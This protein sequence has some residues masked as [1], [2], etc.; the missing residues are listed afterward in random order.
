MR[1]LHLVTKR[2]TVLLYSFLCCGRKKVIKFFLSIFCAARMAELQELLA[3]G[4]SEQKAQET[5]KNRSVTSTILSAI[6][7][8]RAESKLVAPEPFPKLVGNLLYHIGTRAKP[9]IS[10]HIPLLASYV[11][12]GKIDSEAKLNFA[13]AYL[14]DHLSPEIDREKF[15][16]A[17]GVGVQVTSEDVQNTISEVISQHR[18][19]LLQ[20]RY[21]YNVGSLLAAARAKLKF[22][23]GKDIKNELDVQLF[24]LLGPKTALDLAPKPKTKPVGKTTKQGVETKKGAAAAND[25]DGGGGGDQTSQTVSELMKSP[26]MTALHEPGKNH[27]T[28]GYVVTKNTQK[29]LKEHMARTGGR[30]RT[31]FPPEPNGVLHIGHAKAIHVNFGFAKA[32]DGLCFLRYDDTNPEKEEEKFFVAIKEMV[33]WLGYKPYKITHSSDYFHELYEMAEKL[34]KDGLAYVCHQK[35]EEMK[36]FDPPP[37]PWRN[38]PVDENL[39][40]FRAMKDGLFDEGEATLRLKHI[41]EEGKQDPVAYRIKYVP[42]HR[43]GDEWCIYPTY[44]YT[45][46]LCDSLEDITHSLCTKEFQSRRSSYYWLCNALDVYCP[47]QWEYARLNVHR[48][49]V[50][51]RKIASLIKNGIVRDWDD[52]R[53]FTLTAL[54]RRGVPP[55]AIN[56]FVARLGLS[57]AQMAVGPD[58]LDSC[59]RDTLNATAPRTMVVLDPLKVTILNMHSSEKRFEVLDFP[60]HPNSAT[61]MITLLPVIYLERSD[62]RDN[63]AEKDYRRLTCTQSVGLRHAGL[64]ISVKKVLR[65]P[66]GEVQELEVVCCSVEQTRKP[67]AFVH[68]VSDPEKCEVRMY[69][70]LFMHQNPENPDEVPGGFLSDVNPKSLTVVK[71]ALFDEH[72]L[73]DIPTPYKAYQF[74]RQGFFAEKTMLRWSRGCALCGVQ[75]RKVWSRNVTSTSAPLAAAFNSRPMP[76]ISFSFAADEVGLFGKKELRDPTGFY[77][78]KER[79]ISEADELVAEA[80]SQHRTRKLVEIFDDLS[81]SLCRVADLAEFVRIAHPNA[82]FRLAAEDAC[83]AIGGLVEKLN[84]DLKLYESLKDGLESGREKTAFGCDEVDT[85]VAELFKFDFEQC[86]IHLTESKRERVARL[87]EEI[88]Y[89]GQR[90]CSAAN[91]P[92]AVRE[93]DLPAHFAARFRKGGDGTVLISS[94]QADASQETTRELAYKLYLAR[95]HSQ[96]ALLERLLS[97][98]HEMATICGFSTY[99]ERMLSYSL[100][101]NPEFVDE[102]H[103]CLREKL[104]PLAADDFWTMELLKK[105]SSPG[106]GPLA[107]WDPPYYASLTRQKDFGVTSSSVASYFSLG[108]CMEGLD[109]LLQTLYGI[110]LELCEAAPGELWSNDVRKLAVVHEA[111]GLLGYVYCDFFDRHDKPHS[112]CHFTI[113]G[114]R[115]LSDGSYQVPIVVLLLSFPPGGFGT[116]GTFGRTPPCLSP[117]MVDNL[118]HEFGHALHSKGSS[119]GSGPLAPWDP[120]Y[121]AS[122]TRQKDFGVTSSSVASYFSLGSCMEGLDKLLQTLY[123]IRLEL[124]EAAPGE[125]WSNDVRKLAVVHEADGLLGYVYCD[126]F[127]RHDKPHSD[128]H[129]TIQGGRRLSDGSYQVPIV[130]LLLSFPPGGFGTDGT[131]GRTPPCLSPGMVDNLFHEFG[132]ALHSVMGRTRYQH[133]TGT[134]CPTDFAEVPSTMMEFFAGDP[135]VISTFAVH[136]KTGEKMPEELIYRLCGSRHCLFLSEVQNDYYGLPHVPN[137]GWQLRFSHLVG[138]GAKYYSYLMSRAVSAWIWSR[139]FKNDPFDRPGG[140]AV[141]YGLLSH[142][143]AVDPRILVESTVGKKVTPEALSNCLVD[144]LKSKRSEMLHLSVDVLGNMIDRLKLSEVMLRRLGLRKWHTRDKWISG[145]RCYAQAIS[146]VALTETKDSEKIR[147]IGI[148]AHIDSGKTTLTERILYY[149]GRIQEMHEVKGKDNV[150][151]TMDSMELERQRGITIQSAATYTLWKDHN[152]NIIDTPG[153]VDFT[154]EVERALR[155]L[156]GAVLVLCAVGGVQSQTMTVNRQMARYSVPCLAFINKLDRTG[157]NPDRVLAQLRSKLGHN[158]AYMNIPMGKEMNVSGLIDLIEEKAVYFRGSCGEEIAEDSIP[159]EFRALAADRRAELVEHVVNVDELLGEMF[160]EE[161]APTN[162]ELKAAIRRACLKR[163][164]TPVYVG[165]ALKNK[166]VQPLLD[167]ALDFLPNPGEVQNFALLEKEDGGAVEKVPLSANRDNSHPFV[168]LAF[169]LEAGRFGQLTY[170]RVYQGMLKKSDTLF[171]T[172]TRKKVRI[173][174]VVRMHADKLED[175][176]EVYSGD[177]CA[178]FGV[179]CASGDTFVTDPKLRLSME[180]MHVPEPV[181]SMSIAPKDKKTGLENF[182]KA[183]ARFTKEDPTFTV[184]YDDD[185]KELIASGMGELHLEIYGQRMEREFNCPVVMGKPKVAFRESLVSPVEFDYLHKKQSGGAGQYGRV[186]GILEP[187]PP[188]KN[189]DLEFVDQTVGTNIPKNFVPSVEKG[190]RAFCEHGMLSGSRVAGIRFRLIDGDHHVVDSNDWSFQFAA[191][192]AMRQTYGDSSWQILEPIML[193]EVMVP[194]EFQGPILAMLTKRSGII[195]NTE[196]TDDWVTLTSEVPLNEMFGFATELRSQT[197]GK[198]EFAMEYSR[199]APA[200][201]EVQNR[202]VEEYREKMGMTDDKKNKKRN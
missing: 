94:L 19:A 7:S 176:N 61:H 24:D 77:L 59:V 52:P 169:K 35:P 158:A 89:L 165:T 191:Q 47:V 73:H 132:H 113:Q 163:Q 160:L 117:G 190:F 183:V 137:T 164:F 92:R 148:S 166:G 182:T 144:E 93:R 150:G 4:L 154:V 103:R 84:T 33:E 42:H 168:G 184:K 53:L 157:A 50:S 105:G 32:H 175:V 87:N 66:N 97:S 145:S 10:A 193:V 115:R 71:E 34:I 134:R 122:L 38:R 86:G 69:E 127:D 114:G 6:S 131:F 13:L 139:Y 91:A 1:I 174:R 111:D 108:S 82:K 37:S 188:E 185:N 95:D 98:R 40:L 12:S 126:F 180:S 25:V 48:T 81:D 3:I 120:P 68:W 30:V 171:N 60:S 119:P 123:G 58:Y 196:A 194:A 141:R 133:V 197:Q 167:G 56:N 177:I 130:V 116:D 189:T 151:A 76:K 192:G 29:L 129:F 15:D 136:Y 178:V 85:R 17:V 65:G 102:F 173:P 41:L 44:D 199:Y 78:L 200:L 146:K 67:K 45:H 80:C 23:D 181:I 22:G 106:S 20:H 162:P 195:T 147:N 46:C 125:L 55:E 51:K 26:A 21:G 9:Q 198:G 70:H 140:E 72:I 49:V 64:V 101:R 5:L 43:T 202:I 118:F 28:D 57:G 155:V 135:R 156:D 110:R 159:A 104:A 90:F 63:D 27:T 62:F 124:C 75:L 88:L 39:R 79:A 8:A 143:G 161:K 14:M 201:P 179:D 112:D 107:P 138:Y 142:G 121:Y 96:E 170:V 16:A 100:G 153:H 187:L 2:I 83:L 54:R 36:G 172:R 109:K 74:E 11:S 31:R 128:C 18:E 186:I 152:I 99:S 149:T